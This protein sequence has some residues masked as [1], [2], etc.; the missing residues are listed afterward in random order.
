MVY[1]PEKK[2]GTKNS[3]F[4]SHR[5]LNMGLQTS[6]HVRH[7]TY[8]LKPPSL[9]SQIWTHLLDSTIGNPFKTSLNQVILMQMAQYGFTIWI[10]K[11][12]KIRKEIINSECEAEWNLKAKEYLKTKEWKYNM[13]MIIKYDQYHNRASSSRNAI[14]TQATK[15]IQ[16]CIF[17][18]NTSIYSKGFIKVTNLKYKSNKTLLHLSLMGTI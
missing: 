6:P 16:T 13:H 15:R 1:F 9:L 5:C 12:L 4:N 18:Q 2:K 7:R 8:E 3:Y 14:W 17:N 10:Y 11:F